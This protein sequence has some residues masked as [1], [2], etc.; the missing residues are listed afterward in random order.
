MAICMLSVVAAAKGQR[1]RGGGAM[2]ARKQ[3]EM[4]DNVL[5]GVCR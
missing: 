1:T 5:A 2:R 3:L 4:L